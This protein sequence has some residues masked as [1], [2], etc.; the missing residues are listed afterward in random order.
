MNTTLMYNSTRMISWQQ[1]WG[2]QWSCPSREATLIAPSFNLF[3]FVI[4][5]KWGQQEALTASYTSNIRIGLSN[6]SH[7]PIWIISSGFLCYLQVFHLHQKH[8]RLEYLQRH[9][10]GNKI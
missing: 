3:F 5:K 1:K 7:P 2:Q 6:I 4:K 9:S 8:V 10:K